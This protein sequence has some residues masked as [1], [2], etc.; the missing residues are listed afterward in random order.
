MGYGDTYD[1]HP[2]VRWILT[3]TAMNDIGE[4][5]FENR[6]DALMK[7]NTIAMAQLFPGRKKH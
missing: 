2:R 4:G 1:V 5:I 6:G 3:D 7:I